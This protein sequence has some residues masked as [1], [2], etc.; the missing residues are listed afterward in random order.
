[1]AIIVCCPKCGARREADDDLVG[2]KFQCPS[3]WTSFVVSQ[4]AL[5]DTLVTEHEKSGCLGFFLIVFFML[6]GVVACLGVILLSFSWTYYAFAGG[7]LPILGITLSGGFWTGLLW[8]LFI[9]TLVIIV[10]L[11]ACV[12]YMS[13]AIAHFAKNVPSKDASSGH[14]DSTKSGDRSGEQGAPALEQQATAPT[15]EQT[16]E[17]MEQQLERENHSNAPVKRTAVENDRP[18]TSLASPIC[19]MCKRDIP[20][21]SRYC[22]HCGMKVG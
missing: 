2:K 7:T 8:F 14:G 13:P 20:L 3:C 4:S 5:R 18:I 21:E 19:S 6:P 9:D 16:N 15:V 1:M 12:L 10:G 22:K 11:G 17:R